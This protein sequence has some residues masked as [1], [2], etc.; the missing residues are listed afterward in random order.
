MDDVDHED[1]DPPPSDKQYMIAG[2][3][4]L[5]VVGILFAIGFLV[6]KV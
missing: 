2:A 4:F 5:A 3:M 6:G 1:Y